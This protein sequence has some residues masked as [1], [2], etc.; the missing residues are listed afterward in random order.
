ML[1]RTL[2]QRIRTASEAPFEATLLETTEPPMYHRIAS[3]V[4]RLHKLG[5]SNKRIALSLGVGPKTTAKALAW[6]A[7]RDG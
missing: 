3:E 7:R 4:D 1:W 5:L 2:S 6:W